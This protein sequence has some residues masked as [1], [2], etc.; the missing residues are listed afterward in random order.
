MPRKA[1]TLIELLVV[2]AIIA[3]LAAILFPVFAQAKEAAKKTAALSNAKQLGTAFNIYL[4]DSDDV[5]PLAFVLRPNGGKIGIGVGMPLPANNGVQN[6]AGSGIWQTPGRIEMASA[7]WFNAIQTYMKSTELLMLPGAPTSTMFTTDTFISG[8][9]ISAP[10]DGSL[11]MN[12]FMHRY[13]ATAVASPSVAVL[14]WPGQGKIN[15][16]G[17]LNANPALDCGNT[18]DDCQFNPG[19]GASAVP[20]YGTA[21]GGDHGVWY[22]G[23]TYNSYWTYGKR[24]PIVRVDSSAK[25]VPVGSVVQPNVG[26][27]DSGFTD[28]FAEIGPDGGIGDG[29]VGYWGCDTGDHA[30]TD[31]GADQYWCYFRPDRTK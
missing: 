27:P 18:V 25:V 3:I 14:A 7:T 17:R 13:S 16:H 21:S 8:A 10:K 29:N 2:I 24:M 31:A 6:P 30:A 15:F 23:P 26:A 19:G 4:T 5:M 11:T 28:P 9:G 1:F 20:L 22:Y 12:G